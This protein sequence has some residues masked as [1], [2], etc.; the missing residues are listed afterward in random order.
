MFSIPSKKTFSI[1]LHKYKS[2]EEKD[3]KIK[4]VERIMKESAV[5]CAL[6]YKRNRRDVENSR[7][8]EYQSCDYVC[9]GIENMNI[10]TQ[11]YSTYK[12]YYDNNDY[13]LIKDNIKAL[14]IQSFQYNITTIYGGLEILYPISSIKCFK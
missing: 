13:E 1:D 4:N 7:E 11:D 9:D 14:F 12:L 5:D 3:L 6:N 2:S 8:C 10:L